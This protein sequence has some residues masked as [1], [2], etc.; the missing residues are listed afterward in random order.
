MFTKPYR[1]SSF[2][3]QAGRQ[4]STNNAKA[5]DFIAMLKTWVNDNSSSVP[6]HANHRVAPRAIATA[7]MR[8]RQPEWVK[9]LNVRFVDA[10]L[11]NT[12]F[13]CRY[14]GMRPTLSGQFCAAYAVVD[15]PHIFCFVGTDDESRPY[16]VHAQGGV[17]KTAFRIGI[18]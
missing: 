3:H 14:A 18:A 4:S 13:N 5:S 7:S 12:A 17:P 6:T 15:R 8:K 11:A 1:S 10:S 9:S 2:S 16:V